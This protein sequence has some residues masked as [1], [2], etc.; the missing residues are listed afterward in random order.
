MDVTVIGAG[1]SGLTTA[2]ALSQSGHRVSIRAAAPFTDTVS[3]VAAAV[4]TITDTPPT[5]RTRAW[6]LTSREHFA[7]WATVSDSGVMACVQ[8]ELERLP[9]EPSWW[10]TTP[11]VR[12]LEASEV[13]PGYASGLRIEGFTIDPGRY[14]PRLM[15]MLDANGV[16]ILTQQVPTIDDV[17]GEVVVNCAGLGAARLV[18]DSAM[19]PILGQVVVVEDPGLDI[20]VADE[21]DP[22][23][24]TYAYPRSGEVVLGG[25][26]TAGV[27]R[28]DDSEPPDP[29]PDLSQRILDD[30]IAVE[31]RLA[32]ARVRTVRVGERPGR[33]EVR[34][35]ADRTS[36]GRPLVHNYGHSGV[37]YVLSWGCALEVAD[38]I[39]ASADT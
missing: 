37:G 35:E 33:P 19:F 32:G 10:E 25:L 13:P 14:L 21:S 27:L 15:A 18:R 29:D 26:R 24:I 7:A 17:P 20:A 6:A 11:W 28:P 22:D 31:P 3:R 16:E 23:H 5:L 4:W 12:R 30:A 34:V 9:R 39:A 2:V 1:V 38:L 8:I 36:D